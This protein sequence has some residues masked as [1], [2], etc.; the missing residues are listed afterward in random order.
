ML[1]MIFCV[2]SPRKDLHTSL[3]TAGNVYKSY[4]W[5]E[6]ALEAT[7]LVQS[8]FKFFSICAPWFKNASSL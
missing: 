4:L 3:Q 8:S 7:V 5:V 2:K 6:E 1:N